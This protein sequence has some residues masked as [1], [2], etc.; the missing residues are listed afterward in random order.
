MNTNMLNIIKRIVAEQ[1]EDILG[2]PQRLKAFFLDYAKDEPKGERIAFGRCVEMGFYAEL[3]NT[4]NSGERQR[5]KAALAGQLH[6]KTSI[7]QVSCAVAIDLM[8]AVIFGEAAGTASVQEKNISAVVTAPPKPA[9]AGAKKQPSAEYPRDYIPQKK[10]TVLLLCFFL[11][12][13][14]VHR[15]YTGKI[16]QGIITLAIIAILILVSILMEMDW[17]WKMFPE[18]LDFFEDEVGYPLFGLSLSVWWIV[19]IVRICLGKYK[20]KQGYPLVKN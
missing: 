20:G 18:L 5:K 14:G 1:G 7:D 17:A 13:Y 11:G 19:D 9:P 15:F 10:L 8:E 6:D 16:K 2:N 3:K 12:M 4:S